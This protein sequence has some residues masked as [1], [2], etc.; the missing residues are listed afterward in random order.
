MKVNLVSRSVHGLS[1][2]FCGCNEWLAYNMI[3]GRVNVDLVGVVNAIIII[4]KTLL[5]FLSRRQ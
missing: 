1:M 4:T 3:G 2:E 5:S